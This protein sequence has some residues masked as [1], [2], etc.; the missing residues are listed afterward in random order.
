MKGAL[1]LIPNTLGSNETKNVLPPL[2]NEVV[3]MI[4]FY[5]AEDIRTARRFLIKAGLTNP[6]DDL[7]FFVL[8]KHTNPVELNQF[9]GKVPDYENIGM[10]SEAGL[11]CIA[12]PGNLAVNIAH[13]TGRP[14]KPLTGP[15][16]IFLGLMGSGMNG[17]H[18]LFHGYLP[19]KR[20]ERI[21]AI[22]KL[23]QES[24]LLNQTQIFIEAPYRNQKLL[25]DI[26][27]TCR[28]NT[29]LCLGIDLTTK[30]E[31]ITT[32]KIKTW[33]IDIPDIHKRQVIFLIYQSP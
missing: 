9:I 28:D 32:R 22:R 20:D 30:N 19:V 31:F 24:R 33:R 8:N 14:V 29:R 4:R 7:T 5:I 25:E 1:Y 11:P 16:S 17:Q 27:A 2:V 13:E 26:L 12:D 3:N 10:I 15:S 23:E 21:K 18:F 6:V